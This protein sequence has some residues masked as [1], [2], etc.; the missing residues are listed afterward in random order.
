MRF[1]FV[2]LQKHQKQMDTHPCIASP[3]IQENRCSNSIGP[4]TA[5]T[6]LERFRLHAQGPPGYQGLRTAVLP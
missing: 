2:F 3:A 1:F 4:D 6:D 5:V